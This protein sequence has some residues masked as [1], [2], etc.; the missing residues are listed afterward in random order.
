MLMKLPLPALVP[1]LTLA[2]CAAPPLPAAAPAATGTTLHVTS[3]DPSRSVVLYRAPDP[4][5]GTAYSPGPRMRGGYQDPD[6]SPQLRPVE[7]AEPDAL[8]FAPCDHSLGDPAGEDLFVGG[9]GIVSSS[10][11]HLSP[12]L[13]KVQIKVSPKAT[14]RR[15]AGTVLVALGGAGVLGG[16]LVLIATSVATGSADSSALKASAGA[17]GA[18]ATLLAAGI[19]LVVTGRTTYVFSRPAVALRF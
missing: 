3:D 4:F 9:E 11:F 19:A 2:G 14:P 10:R 7:S 5:A 6:P 17:L 18:G 12:R 1:L 13:G 8:C 15:T 16:G